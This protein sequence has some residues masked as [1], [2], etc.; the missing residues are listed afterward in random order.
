LSASL[1]LRAFILLETGLF[2]HG[3]AFLFSPAGLNLTIS[4]PNPP[5]PSGR[6]Q[7][8]SS[9]KPSLTTTYLTEMLDLGIIFANWATV[10]N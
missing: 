3:V 5:G 9:P 10:D 1:L 2:M 8:F 4:V 6:P 7:N